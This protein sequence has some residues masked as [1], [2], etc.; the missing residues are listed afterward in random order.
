M[1]QMN[2]QQQ[3]N[4]QQAQYAQQSSNQQPQINLQQGNS[5]QPANSMSTHS[6]NIQNQDLAAIF[7]ALYNIKQSSQNQRSNNVIPSPSQQTNYEQMPQSQNQPNPT[8]TVSS[9]NK[10]LNSP[11]PVTN[12][13]SGTVKFQPAFTLQAVP[14]NN[15]QQN[16]QIFALPVHK[17][18]TNDQSQSYSYQNQPVS[19][20][21]TNQHTAIMQSPIL[22]IPNG[23]T[24]SLQ[25]QPIVLTL[26]SSQTPTAQN[27]PTHSMSQTSPSQPIMFTIQN[28]SSLET[29][30]NQKISDVPNQQQGINSPPMDK[31]SLMS[32]VMSQI[33]NPQG[34]GNALASILPAML[35]TKSEKSSSMK[36]LLPL[37]LS[38]MSEKRSCCGCPH[39]GCKNNNHNNNELTKSE[40]IVSTGYANQINY[41]QQN[42]AEV[43]AKM[44]EFV[45][46]GVE[47]AS[48][49]KKPKEK[50]VIN[51]SAENSED[52][53]VAYDSEE[54]YDEE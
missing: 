48:S 21:M 23:Q 52:E 1:Q 11:S 10:P 18:N 4:A 37:I 38:I 27:Q 12:S 47:I 45:D 14:N 34:N 20:P 40:P 32:Y 2:Y 7:S 50:V 26:Q 3:S 6:L 17:V 30:Q 33:Q 42:P 28:P 31:E 16:Q 5:Q 49:N 22:L 36:A 19:N 13:H 41:S 51:K 44:T 9:T 25:S 46:K 8:Y 29:N 53:D 43:L 39:C 15:G 54:E 24:N 35:N